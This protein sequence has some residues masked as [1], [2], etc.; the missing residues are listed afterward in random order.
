M[1][2][3][4]SL[5]LVACCLVVVLMLAS[6]VADEPA[7]KSP[8]VGDSAIEFRLP[9][10]GGDDDVTLSSEYKQGPVVVVVLR[11]Y[12]GYQCPLCSRQVGSFVRAAEEFAKSAHRVIFVYP[13]QAT[14]L[15]QHAE[16][17][18]G[19]NVLPKPLVMVRDPGLKMVTS[20]NLRWDAPQETSYPSTFVIDKEGK[21]RFSKTSRTHGDRATAEEILSE[22]EK[23]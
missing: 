2:S 20:W 7:S 22:L 23:L 19:S 10:V 15:Q 12:P 6:V 11:G 5:T 16:Q 1:K 18:M 14:L 17:F 4:I 21:V 3:F 13:G 8:A 9:M